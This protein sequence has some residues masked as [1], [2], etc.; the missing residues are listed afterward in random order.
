MAKPMESGPEATTDD[1]PG[2]P[3]RKKK[4]ENDT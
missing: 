1:G 4:R 2:R 3:E